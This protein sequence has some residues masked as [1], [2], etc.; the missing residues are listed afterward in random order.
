M[1]GVAVARPLDLH[2]ALSDYAA[3]GSTPGNVPQARL[4]AVRAFRIERMH[5]RHGD[6][7]VVDFFARHMLGG[8]DLGGM[9]H[10]P[11]ATAKRL[12]RLLAGDTGAAAAAVEFATLAESLDRAVATRLDDGPITVRAYV[13]AYRA[14]ARAAD[15]RRQLGLVAFVAD[16]LGGVVHRRMSY[17]AFKMAKRP[18]R[19]AGFGAFYDLLAAGFEAL[20]ADPQAQQRVD[21]WLAAEQALLDRLLA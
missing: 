15:R 14:V 8:V 4:A 13:R 18:A 6:H 20:R 1:T 2:Q 21:E 10:D 3:I 17:M 7:P 9:E 19:A 5:A 12:N 16:D 11:A